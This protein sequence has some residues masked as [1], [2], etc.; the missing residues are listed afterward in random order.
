MAFA[1][2]LAAGASIANAADLAE[3]AAAFVV[4]SSGTTSCSG[5]ALRATVAGSQPLL[6]NRVQLATLMQ[7]YHQL[8]RRI[9]FTNGCFDVLHAGHVACLAQAR[10][11]GD[12][13]IVGL[14]DDA[15]VR[16]LKGADRP[17]NSLED[18]MATLAALGCVDH[19]VPFDE[20]TP[21]E[22]IRI[23]QPQV[24]VK[25]G[26]Y[27]L[28]DLPE[29]ALVREFGGVVKLL[30]YVPDHSTTATLARI[31]FGGEAPAVAS[32]PDAA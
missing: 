9:I 12:V 8:D 7:A 24:F 3:A 15:S 18:R 31:R 30:P 17:V 2:A 6:T 29:A 10:T 27:E 25:G 32:S 19:V 28:E 20:D 13:L 23:I 21:I 16:R 14:N 1:L 26:D 11:F 22:L 4:G 5:A